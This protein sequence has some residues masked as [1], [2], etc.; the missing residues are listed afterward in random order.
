[1]QNKGAFTDS[2]GIR[3]PTFM[4]YESPSFMA[5]EPRLLCHVLEGSEGETH[6]AWWHI[7]VETPTALHSVAHRLSHQIPAESEMSRQNRATR[8]SVQL[9]HLKTPL[10]SE[11]G[12]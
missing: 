7:R 10:A 6:K 4:A 9:S 1:M 12:T 3:T 2:D 8:Y 11:K 5:H